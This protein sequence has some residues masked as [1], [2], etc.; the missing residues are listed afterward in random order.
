MKR[1]EKN[2]IE[3]TPSSGNVFADIGLPNPEE[4]LKKARL[5]VQITDII[6]ERKLTQA[7]AAKILGLPQPKVS[8]LNTGKVLSF[9]IDRLIRLLEKLDQ[10]VE[11][12]VRPRKVEQP[13]TNTKNN[14][15][16]KNIKVPLPLNEH[17]E[18]RIYAKKD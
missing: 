18:I 3:C 17:R 13:I 5:A 14:F 12:K 11:I 6:K 10:E 7:K 16:I 8:D 9:S 2:R 1:K 15:T 4:L